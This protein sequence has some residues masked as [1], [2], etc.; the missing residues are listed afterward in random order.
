MKRKTMINA[1]LLL[2][3]LPLSAL[4]A[5]SQPWTGNSPDT[6]AAVTPK[7]NPPPLFKELDT[8][9]DGYISRQEARRSADVTAR[10]KQLDANRDGK[11]SVD[12]FTRHMPPKM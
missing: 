6:A 12:E 5:S 2:A 8:N 11:I 3:A 7:E 10:F 1:F 4:A 9:H